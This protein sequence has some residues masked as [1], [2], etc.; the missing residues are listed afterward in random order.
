MAVTA[1]QIIKAQ[2]AGGLRDGLVIASTHFYEGTL[3][4]YVAASGHITDVI[5]TTANWFAGIVRREVDNSA[6]AAAAKTIEFYTYG[7]FLLPLPSISQ[8]GVGQIAY[9]VDNY[10]LSLTSTNQPPVGK[11]VGIHST[12]HAWVEINPQA[13]L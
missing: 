3:C 4:F 11:I 13:S 12:T 8:A 5:A 9:A 1:N 6:G 10:V 2:N 7:C